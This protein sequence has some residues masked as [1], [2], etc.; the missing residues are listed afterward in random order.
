MLVFNEVGCAPCGLTLTLSLSLSLSL[1]A[2]FLVTGLMQITG[3][4]SYLSK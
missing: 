3:R 4:P 2:R 1:R